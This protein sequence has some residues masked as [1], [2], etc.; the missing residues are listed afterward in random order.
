MITGTSDR[1]DHLKLTD[2]ATDWSLEF[3]KGNSTMRFA[4]L[5]IWAVSIAIIAS[6]LPARAGTDNVRCVMSTPSCG[7]I[8][9]DTSSEGAAPVV[10]TR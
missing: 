8:A 9:V 7:W 3:P 5:A 2:R 4:I 6:A 10:I 1:R